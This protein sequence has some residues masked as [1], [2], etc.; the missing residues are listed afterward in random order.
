[1]VFATLNT[2]ITQR[3]YNKAITTVIIIPMGHKPASTNSNMSCNDTE[4]LVGIVGQKV[5]KN[6]QS[7]IDDNL[8]VILK[9]IWYIIS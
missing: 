8:N 9:I 7:W 5:K 3:K 1:M 2:S 4:N 6:H